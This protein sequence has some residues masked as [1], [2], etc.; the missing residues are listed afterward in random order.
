V[1]TNRELEIRGVDFQQQ[2]TWRNQVADI[3]RHPEY[4]PVDLGADFDLLKPVQRADGADAT[5]DTSW[6]GGGHRH[7]DRL[8]MPGRGNCV[9]RNLGAGLCGASPARNHSERGRHGDTA[10]DD[11]KEAQGFQP[12]KDHVCF[13]GISSASGG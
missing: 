9:W 12:S 4:V 7:R 13:A 3:V 1:L 11:R 6:H 10:A 2:V 5:L 8:S